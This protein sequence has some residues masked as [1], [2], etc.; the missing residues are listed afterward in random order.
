MASAI[1]GDGGWRLPTMDE[2]EQLYD[3][4]GAGAFKG[5]FREDCGSGSVVDD[6]WYWSCTEFRDN[7]SLVYFVR[8]ASGDD[9]WD[10]KDTYSLSSRLVRTEPRP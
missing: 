8:F 1:R 5:T 2:L 4:R 3:Y 10:P 6:D 9:D 7:S